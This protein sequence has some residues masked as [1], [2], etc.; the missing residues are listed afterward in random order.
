[1]FAVDKSIVIE[2]AGGKNISIVTVDGKQIYN[3]VGS[4][5]AKI[6]VAS[7]LGLFG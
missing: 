4:D 6:R 7:L 5:Y 1:M 3:S 2:G